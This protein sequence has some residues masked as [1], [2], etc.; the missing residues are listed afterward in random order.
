MYPGDSMKKV[1]G[2][3]YL[4]LLPN[5]KFKVIQFIEKDRTQLSSDVIR[6]FKNEFV[7]E[8][9]VVSAV[10]PDYVFDFETHVSLTSGERLG[11]WRRIGQMPI[12][13]RN[14]TLFRV[15]QDYGTRGLLKSSKWYVWYANEEMQFLGELDPTSRS[16]EIGWI[17]NPS[18]FVERLSTGRQ[19]HF[20]P[21]G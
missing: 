11:L 5:G 7:S 1:K 14:R 13:D 4:V 18:S 16:A 20:Y 3:I 10:P 17:V 21:A 19:T 2:S 15:C 6:A 12:Q 9:A 8:A